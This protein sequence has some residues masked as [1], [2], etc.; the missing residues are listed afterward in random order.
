MAEESRF[1]D[2]ESISPV[3]ESTSVSKAMETRLGMSL[4]AVA[5]E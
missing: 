5:S 4:E 1:S 3:A 2:S